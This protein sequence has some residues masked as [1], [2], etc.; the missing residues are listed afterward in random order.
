MKPF[1][2]DKLKNEKLQQERNIIP[3]I[4]KKVRNADRHRPLTGCFLESPAFRLS[5][6][7]ISFEEIVKAI[8]FKKTIAIINHPHPEK[9]PNQKV[10]LV[11]F[12]KYIYMVPFVE[13]SEKR[14]LK[15]I[16]PS[17]KETKKYLKQ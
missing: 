10:F 17:R 5:R 11:K 7:G 3:I 13:D 15:T 12:K 14:F 4:F 16:I 6:I 8:E 2:W 9:Y 1:E